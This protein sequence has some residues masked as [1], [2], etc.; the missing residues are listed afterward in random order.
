MN[1]NDEAV[2]IIDNKDKLPVPVSFDEVRVLQREAEVELNIQRRH[3]NV[4]GAERALAAVH[5]GGEDDRARARASGG[6]TARLADS[7]AHSETGH[8]EGA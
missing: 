5:P 7:A 8:A 2:E 1:K 6:A 3:S 4:V